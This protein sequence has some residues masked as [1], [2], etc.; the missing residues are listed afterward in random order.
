MLTKIS[1]QFHDIKLAL[2]IHFQYRIGV[3]E[4]FHAFAVKI[5]EPTEDYLHSI[6]TV[7]LCSIKVSCITFFPIIEIQN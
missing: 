3:I 1:I 2:S 5:D 6:V 4:R 7:S